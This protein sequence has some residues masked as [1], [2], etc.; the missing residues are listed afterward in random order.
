ME[1]DSV[2]RGVSRIQKCV[3]KIQSQGKNKM[4]RYNN[5]PMLR[6]KQGL[7][8]KKNTKS[9]WK[10]KEEIAHSRWVGESVQ[11]STTDVFR[12]F[13]WHWDSKYLS[14]K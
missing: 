7:R 8:N 13:Q 6:L 10:K 11:Y 12:D 1:I 5:L 4:L 9:Y 14:K 3:K 2:L